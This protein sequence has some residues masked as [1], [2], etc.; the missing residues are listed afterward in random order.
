MAG[1]VACLAGIHKSE[2]GVSVSVCCLAAS[3]A[4]FPRMHPMSATQAPVMISMR[5]PYSTVLTAPDGIASNSEPHWQPAG[6]RAPPS[7]GFSGLERME[8][9][10]GTRRAALEI[11]VRIGASANSTSSGRPGGWPRPRRRSLQRLLRC[12][13]ARTR[14][15]CVFGSQVNSRRRPGDPRI[16]RSP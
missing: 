11:C 6:G 5:L 3:P 9:L 13:P 12:F 7:C 4:R 10:V 2:R 14:S 1:A 16:E 15:A 8:R